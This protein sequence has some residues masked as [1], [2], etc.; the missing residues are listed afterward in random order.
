MKTAT[1]VIGARVIA[2]LKINCAI[3]ISAHET[4]RIGINGE[5]IE[6]EAR[7]SEIIGEQ[8]IIDAEIGEEDGSR[9]IDAIGEGA[10]GI[11]EIGD[12]NISA[13]LVIATQEIPGEIGIVVDATVLGI[14]P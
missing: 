11:I 1:S 4:L 2:Q 14:Q 7:I 6:A 12:A 13:K 10:E 9:I 5:I 8:T 3:G